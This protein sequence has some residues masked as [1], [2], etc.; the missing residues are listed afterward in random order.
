MA[1]ANSLRSII[2]ALC[3][4]G[5]IATAKFVAAFFTGSGA[6]LAEAVHSAAD[7][8]NQVLLLIGLRQ[9]KKPPT[10][11]MPLGHGKAVYFWSFVVALLLFTLG[12]VYSVY[13]GLHKLA[14]PE[15]LRYPLVALGVLAFGLAAEWVSLRACLTE[16]SK[17]REERS[18]WTWFKESRQSEL[19]VIFAEDIAAIAGLLIAFVAILVTYLTADPIY[20]ALGTISIGTLLIVIAAIIAREMRDLL[21]GQGVE[22]RT[23]N[24][25]KAY[26]QDQ[27]NIETIFSLLTLQMGPDVMV[28]IKAKMPPTDSAEA[29][30]AQINATE[31]DFRNQFPEVRWLFFEPDNED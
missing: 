17:V 4:N 26:L 19:I 21:I 28:A 13:E 22:P 18:L 16:V 20:D 2:Y 12:G 10:F 14:E 5:A 6:M 30:I 24:R 23:H 15:P 31:A 1:Q 8:T 29:L 9:A 25:M 27:T 3:A 7:C 11:D